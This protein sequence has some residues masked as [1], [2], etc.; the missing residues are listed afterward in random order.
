MTAR[1]TDHA[2]FEL[3]RTYDAPCHRAFAAWAEPSAKQRW[4]TGSGGSDYDLD[5]R[6]GGREVF[7]GGPQG[8]P[9]YLYQATFADIVPDERIVYSYTMDRDATRISVSLATVTF[10]SLGSST[11][12]AIT[13]YG[14]F[15]DGGDQVELRREGVTSQLKVLAALLD[16]SAG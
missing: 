4:F 5:F 13:E 9:T 1:S 15:L 10:Q 2:S 12:L 6:I 16:P 8:G 11:A 7:R 14:V 3:Q